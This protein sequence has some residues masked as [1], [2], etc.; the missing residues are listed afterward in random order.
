M[1][2]RISDH[3][4]NTFYGENYTSEEVNFIFQNAMNGKS[5]SDLEINKYK[6][7]VLFELASM[8]KSKSWAQQFHVGAIRN[9]NAKMLQELGPDQGFDS[10]GD[11]IMA[12]NMSKFFGKLSKFDSLTKTI[13]YNL[14]PALNVM[15]FIIN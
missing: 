12:E 5:P 15:P 9:N 7:A 6:S 4:H 3:G 11:L 8:N 14:N 2:C 10:L 1:G 13:V